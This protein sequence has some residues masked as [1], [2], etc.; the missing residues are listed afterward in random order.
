MRLI[1]ILPAFLFGLFS[2]AAVEAGAVVVRADVSPQMAPD[3]IPSGVPFTVDIYMENN[4]GITQ[5]GYSLPFYFYSPDQSLGHARHR[6]VH[7]IG[8]Q[9][10]DFPHIQFHDSSIVMHHEFDSIWNVMNCWYGFSWDGQLPDTVNHTAASMIGWEPGQGEKLYIQFA[11][12][13]DET[14][15]FC[16]DS[17]DYPIDTYDWLFD[18]GEANHPFNGPYCWTVA[19]P[20]FICGDLDDN[21]L[22]NLLDITRLI[23]YLYLGGGEPDPLQAADSNAD[24]EVNLLDVTYLIDFIYR[25]QAAP[26]CWPGQ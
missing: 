26:V 22:V 21:G 24:G 18:P 23:G 17:A 11:F 3:T 6:N 10:I 4:D 12:F 19:E 2:V 16:I 13:T 1:S 25:G 20:P 9:T 7:G 8:A 15:T 5:L 14:G